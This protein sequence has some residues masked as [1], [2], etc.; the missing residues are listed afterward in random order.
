MVMISAVARLT[1]AVVSVVHR[2]SSSS[3]E[4]TSSKK[5]YT[6]II[7]SGITSLRGYPGS[8]RWVWQP[9]ST[10]K[11]AG[12]LALH[13][14]ATLQLGLRFIPV[15]TRSILRRMISRD[16]PGAKVRAVASTRLTQEAFTCF[17]ATPCAARPC[18]PLHT[19]EPSGNYSS[20][21]EG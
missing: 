20:H 4:G 5:Q 6:G 1:L 21:Y 15:P 12:Y 16:Q 17:S 9:Q 13:L 3:L 18:S 8:G 11:P 10:E 7:F 14:R 2:L 19:Q